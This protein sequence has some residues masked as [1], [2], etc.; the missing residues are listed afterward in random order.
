MNSASVKGI[1][2]PQDLQQL[3]GRA[4]VEECY[5]QFLR[6]EATPE[7]LATWIPQVEHGRSKRVVAGRIRWS[8]EGRRVSAKA[9]GLLVPF[10]VDSACELRLVGAALSWIAGFAALG[11]QRRNI[12]RLEAYAAGIERL[13]VANTR[14]TDALNRRVEELS[15]TVLLLTAQ[16]EQAQG[17][18]IH[19]AG[20]HGSELQR[21][22]VTMEE[23]VASMNRRLQ[24]QLAS[25]CAENARLFEALSRLQEQVTEAKFA[26]RHFA[27]SAAS[28]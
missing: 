14:A 24:S 18:F 12:R 3:H 16:L 23:E 8:P 20:T 28:E 1:A 22:R 25:H 13:A 27:D 6:R 4:F 5:R 11:R 9:P 19:S 10:V 26:V 7:E 17:R 21:L 15:A 2:Y